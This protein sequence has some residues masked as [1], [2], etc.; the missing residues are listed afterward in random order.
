MLLTNEFDT[1]RQ[2]AFDRGIYQSGD[3][4]TQIIKLQEEVG[5]LAKAILANNRDEVV[6]AI[7]DCVIVLTNLAGL[8]EHH[9]C[10][11]CIT[12]RGIGGEISDQADE[13]GLRSWIK[14]N[15]CGNLSIETCINKAFDE[16]K[17]RSGVMNNG[18]FVKDK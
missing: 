13:L 16:V 8:A 3:V 1:V 18:T 11:R 5:E 10:D 9:F 15:D 2:W 14:C 4:K 6:D 12:C 17:N 7:G